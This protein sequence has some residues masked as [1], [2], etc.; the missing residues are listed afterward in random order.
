MANKSTKPRMPIKKAAP[1][2][3]PK[4][5]MQTFLA[6]RKQAYAESVFV[7]FCQNSE[8]V[9]AGR[10]PEDVAR[11]AVRYA[12]ALLEALFLKP[13]EEAV[14]KGDVQEGK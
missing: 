10:V 6:Q 4:E 12:D 1:K 2:P 3:D 8:I 11:D 14:K 5:Q 7:A 13:M 9:N